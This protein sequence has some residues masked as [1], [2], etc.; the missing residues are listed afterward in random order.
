[1]HKLRMVALCLLAVYAFFSILALVDGVYHLARS[2]M[3]LFLYAGS[4]ASIIGM[5][6]LLLMKPESP[7][8]DILKDNVL[9]LWLKRKKLEEAKRIKDLENK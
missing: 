9:S 7:D 3:E 2:D 6:A 4:I 1:M 8:G 5:I